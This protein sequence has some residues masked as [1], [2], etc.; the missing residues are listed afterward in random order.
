MLVLRLSRALSL[1]KLCFLQ[2]QKPQ[3][4]I[5]LNRTCRPNHAY[6]TVLG[7]PAAREGVSIFPA[8]LCKQQQAEEKQSFT[9]VYDCQDEEPKRTDGHRASKDVLKLPMP[10]LIHWTGPRCLSPTTPRRR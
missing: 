9:I 4:S 1:A 2:Q 5:E 7:K 6:E 3:Q 8:L 10:E